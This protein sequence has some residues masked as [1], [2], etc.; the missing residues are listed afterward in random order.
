MHII[1]DSVSMFTQGI[2]IADLLHVVGLYP[3]DPKLL[4]LYNNG[5][6]PSAPASRPSSGS[7][8]NIRRHRQHS[9]NGGRSAATGG[10]TASS[11]G[12]AATNPFTFSSVSGLMHEQ[13][14]LSIQYQRFASYCF[15]RLMA[16]GSVSF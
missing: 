4:R 15:D 1:A 11:S 2:L 5:G 9:A 14:T 16:E 10:E 8:S 13:G 3:H 12:P 6:V 7:A